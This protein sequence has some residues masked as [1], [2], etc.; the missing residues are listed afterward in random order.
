MEGGGSGGK[1]VDEGVGKGGKGVDEGVQ[2]GGKGGDEGLGS[3][4][5]GGGGRKWWEV[6]GGG[7]GG[8]GGEGVVMLGPRFRS[9]LP[10]LVL[11]RRCCS[12]LVRVG[13]RCR[14]SL[15]RVVA[16]RCWHASLPFFVGARRCLGWCCAGV[17]VRG[18]SSCSVGGR[19]APCA[20]VI[21]GWG[22]VVSSWSWVGYRYVPWALVVRGRGVFVVR[23]WSIVSADAR[24]VD[25]GCCGC[26]VVV[27]RALVGVE[28]R[29]EGGRKWREG[30]G[31]KRVE[32]RE[33]RR[34]GGSGG[35]GVV[36][37]ALVAVR[38][39]RASLPFV[40]GTRRCRF[41]LACVGAVCRWVGDRRRPW[42]GHC[43]LW[44]GVVVVRGGRRGH[45]WGI[46]VVRGR[47]S[48]G[49]GV[50]VEQGGRRLHARSPSIGGGVVVVRVV[51]SLSIGESVSVVRIGMGGLTNGRRTRFVVRRLVATSP[52]ATWHLE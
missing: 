40:V 32:G 18:G 20:I 13:P 46:V 33:W 44:M 42:V 15:A 41:S 23:G 52:M 11:G 5:K 6:S 30:S 48:F 31:G 19:R 12:S 1:G 16:V 37:R 38:H 14:S 45:G 24:C 49:W 25:G 47:S 7:G 21:R 50:V 9:S 22:I 36:M 51:S 17:V 28:G 27:E 4:G 8:S 34:G 26:V 29:E 3:E 10:W 39:W 35:E 2:S 43:R